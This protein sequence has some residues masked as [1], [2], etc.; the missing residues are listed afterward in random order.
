MSGTEVKILAGNKIVL[1]LLNEVNN[2]KID[3]AKELEPIE[4]GALPTPGTTP[5]GQD[6]K[7]Q[8]S[9]GTAGRTFTH[10]TLTGGSKALTSKE[11]G[12]FYWNG[13]TRVWSYR[14]GQELPNNRP[15]DFISSVAY[16]AGA[17]IYF[18]GNEIFEVLAQTLVGE[19]PSTMPAKFKSV[20]KGGDERVEVALES[21]LSNGTGMNIPIS[22]VTTNLLRK[23]DGVLVVDSVSRMM[24]INDLQGADILRL[25]NYFPAVASPQ[26]TG[27]YSAIAFY[28][29]NTA[30]TSVMETQTAVVASQSE[31]NTYIP[32]PPSVVKI[33][34]TWTNFGLGANRT[35]IIQLLSGQITEEDGVKKYIDEKT[36]S[37][38]D[39]TVI[40]NYNNRLK[41]DKDYVSDLITIDSTFTLRFEEGI[42]NKFG[43]V[44]VLKFT[45]GDIAFSNGF[46]V[47]ESSDNY[48]P[49]MGNIIYCFFEYQNVRV[50]IKNSD[51]SRLYPAD[52]ATVFLA[53]FS[54]YTGSLPEYTP[55][56]G[57]LPSFSGTW[58][59]LDN[60]AVATGLGDNLLVF[61]LTKRNEI[62]FKAIC[63]FSH[64]MVLGFNSY[65]SNLQFN[66]TNNN[67]ISKQ[68]SGGNLSTPYV[69][70][71]GV[72][73]FDVHIINGDN[74]KLSINGGAII[75]LNVATDT[76]YRI[77]IGFN[78]NSAGATS[79]Y[80]RI[81]IIN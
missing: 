26:N 59:V 65:L 72:L 73:T 3:Q 33:V 75:E 35:P 46:I 1:D 17:Q 45:G 66:R 4:G 80:S 81:E 2:K 52:L 49:A 51:L 11:I 61:G 16:S 44:N 58:N 76:D 8:V 20:L 12:L 6:Y 57:L 32:I 37:A 78:H 34:L 5:A 36:D 50:L 30:F 70:P 41:F 19:N 21:F 47:D 43:K 31:I 48:N 60:K 68:K 15:Q 38:G 27:V 64:I 39:F 62:R 13:T 22:G 53:D 40:E 67:I 42:H 77:L 28:T 24:T 74:V 7:M 71:A 69:F 56:I 14:N 25:A 55:N 29:S 79:N 63:E 10:S 23:S 18:N 9:G 54:N